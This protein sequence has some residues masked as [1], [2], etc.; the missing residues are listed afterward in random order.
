MFLS[1]G[2]W[3]AVAFG[4]N[5]T[6]YDTA[7][8][9]GSS[10]DLEQGH[11]Q[12]VPPVHNVNIYGGDGND[13]IVGGQGTEMLFGGDGNDLIRA[14]IG[15]DMILGG[16]GDD[17]IHGGTGKQTLIG[18]TGDDTIWGGSGAQLLLGDDGQDVIHGGSG[19]QTLMGGAGNDAIW[20]GSGVQSLQG[21]D[22]ND[23]LHAGSGNETLSGGTGRDTFVF[24]T[25]NGNDVITDFQT[26]QDSIEITF[27]LGGLKPTQAQDLLGNISA[28]RQGNAILTI[29][30]DFRLVLQH[31]TVHQIQTHAADIFKLS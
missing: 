9:N 14:S 13:T 4:P 20:G 1:W 6:D 7:H 8:W 31:V 18:G 12:L 28:D 3:N 26:G 24:S 25:A 17:E 22:G 19:A 29:G 23:V 16:A 5:E 2:D 27:D 15:E 30:S 11:W 10:G 21:W